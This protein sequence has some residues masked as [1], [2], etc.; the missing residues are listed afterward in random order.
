MGV[1]A[2]ISTADGAPLRP[3][4]YPPAWAIGKARLKPSKRVAKFN[5]H[6]VPKYK[7]LHVFLSNSI[8]EEGNYL[9]ESVT[10]KYA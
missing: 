4:I 1:Q 10:A 3:Q 2:R 7:R 5:L 9:T 8:L 6:L